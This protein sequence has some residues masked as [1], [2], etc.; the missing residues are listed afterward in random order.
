MTSIPKRVIDAF[1]L[2]ATLIATQS[3][4]DE[5][6]GFT[7]SPMVGKYLPAKNRNLDDGNF[8]SLGLGYQFD[9][10]WAMEASF[11]SGSSDIGGTSQDADLDL[12]RL[13]AL[14]YFGESQLR[15]YLVGGLGEGEFSSDFGDADDTFA[16]FGVGL[17]YAVNKVFALRSDFRL[18][19][20][21][22]SGESDY[23]A[24]I[25]AI[26]TFGTQ[27]KASAPKAR[28]PAAVDSDNDGVLDSRD[29]CPNSTSGVMVDSSGCELDSDADGVVDSR[30][31][32]PDS[33]AKAK[34]DNRGCY[35]TLK[36]NVSVSLN[37]NFANNSDQ[38]IEDSYPEIERLATF[39]TSY[40][41]TDVVIEGHTDSL[42]AAAYNKTLSRKRADAVAKILAEKY[43]ISASR[44][45]AVG[46]GE[47]QPLV[48]N[49][50]PGNRAKNRRVTAVVSATIEKT[51][52]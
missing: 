28:A 40:P 10:H 29:Q 35:E 3:L 39:L 25:G 14:Y 6:S 34:V 45:S 12:L 21:M 48:D 42:G 20:G 51:V 44:V 24:G 5:Q 43:D 52:K 15:P 30:D 7:V 17:H 2:C 41:A 16:N 18:L 50:T 38:V 19:H 13:D 31:A 36:E 26:F 33:Q 37:V 11:L 47:E 9:S 32:C 46:Y 22:D 1:A 27:T 8:L 4:A 49:D 23:L